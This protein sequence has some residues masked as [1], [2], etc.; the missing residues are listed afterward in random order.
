[1][2]HSKRNYNFQ[3]TNSQPCLNESVQNQSNPHN[4]SEQDEFT[5]C[6]SI[7]NTSAMSAASFGSSSGG[8]GGGGGTGTANSSIQRQIISMEDDE[9]GDDSELISGNGSIPFCFRNFSLSLD[10]NEQS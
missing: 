6:D 8:V 1:M 4:L 10:R 3:S 9:L 7:F 2:H 5:T